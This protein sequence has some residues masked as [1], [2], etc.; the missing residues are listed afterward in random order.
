M[1]LKEIGEF[2]FIER[3]TPLFNS[4]LHENQL[5]I[6]DDCAIIPANETEDWLVTTDLLMEGVHFLRDAIT[7]QQLG[8]KSL[9]VNLSDIAAMGGT[10]TGSF[11]SFAIPEG[12][13]V[14]YLDAFMSGY[15]ELSAKY[16]VPLLG[17]DT[18]KSLK[19][20]AINVC[21]MGKCPKGTARKRSMAQVGDLV[22]VTGHLGDSAAGLK[23]VL[24]QPDLSDDGHKHLIE[25]HHKP[26]PQ[27]SE[28]LFLADFAG[29]HAMMDISDGIASDLKHILKASGKAATI[30]IEK[31]P[32]SGTLKNMAAAQ[33]WNAVELAASGGEDYELLVT[34][35]P[36][37]LE[38]IQQQFAECFGKPLYQIGEITEGE[39]R[40]TWKKD[41]REIDF[42]KSGFNHFE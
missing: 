3:F 19:H 33:Q 30:E 37:D 34:V 17:G 31:L 21:V 18:T 28:G 36:H 39:A 12:L 4:L 7:P 13:D 41:G 38:T 26:E 23:I 25:K 16:G 24:D 11:L 14:N 20:F 9:A 29:T 5:G 2:G 22:C 10:P 6:G 42:G 15:H 8:Y 1:K 27:L 40:I 32:I 35:A